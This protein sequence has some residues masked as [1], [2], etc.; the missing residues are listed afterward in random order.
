VRRIL[1]GSAD[2]EV[3]YESE[4]YTH[5]LVRSEQVN[6]DIALPYVFLAAAHV[7]NGATGDKEEIG[8]TEEPT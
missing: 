1:D 5:L 6:I 2:D 8:K 7:V 3:P 4:N